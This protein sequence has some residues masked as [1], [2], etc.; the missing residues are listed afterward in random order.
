M[1]PGDCYQRHAPTGSDGH[2]W[3]P[4][5]PPPVA[6]KDRAACSQRGGKWE[7][8]G[9]TGRNRG[10]RQRSQR[11]GRGRQGRDNCRFFAPVRSAAI[12]VMSLNGGPA[13]LA[14]LI[15]LAGRL[16]LRAVRPLRA[17][18]FD[19]EF[20]ILA[21]RRNKLKGRPNCQVRARVRE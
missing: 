11:A 18:N 5:R 7:S 3:S 8:S 21:R 1:Q 17:K 2:C 10:S 14:R 19:H 12:D 15:P 13:T 16:L 4:Q 9:N 6:T 20:V